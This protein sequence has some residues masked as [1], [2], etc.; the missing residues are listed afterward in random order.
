MADL[1][2]GNKQS[3]EENK[4]EVTLREVVNWGS[5]TYEKGQKLIP[6]RQFYK[7]L[8]K[9]RLIEESPKKVGEK[10]PDIR[11]RTSTNKRSSFFKR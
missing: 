3:I 10:Q 2:E 1:E 4:Q 5:S 7:Y 9:N 6:D 8:Y 11:T